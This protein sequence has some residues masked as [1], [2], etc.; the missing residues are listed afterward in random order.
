MNGTGKRRRGWLRC[1]KC[2]G[3]DAD[4]WIFV[5]FEDW[6]ARY[7]RGATPTHTS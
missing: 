6:G 5:R 2:P 1:G 3:V 7:G 4:G